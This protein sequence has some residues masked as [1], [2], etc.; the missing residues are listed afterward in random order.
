MYAAGAR[1]SLQRGAHR[2]RS[3]PNQIFCLQS[4]SLTSFV[5][6]ASPSVWKIPSQSRPV[7]PNRREPAYFARCFSALGGS[8]SAEKPGLFTIPGLLKPSDFLRLAHSAMEESDRLRASLSPEQEISTVD[9]ARYVL[10]RLDQISKTVCNVIDASEL[11]RNAHA[12]DEWRDEAQQ[13]FTLLQEYIGKLNGDESL[14]DSLTNVIKSPILSE[15]SEEE[16][17]FA[18]LLKS[19]FESEGIHLPAASKEQAQQLQAH[20]IKLETMFVTNITK[21]NKLFPIDREA[22]EQFIPRHVLKA[23]GAEY[24]HGDDGN[25]IHLTTTSPISNSI[26]SF[27]PSSSLRKEVYMETMTACP[28]NLNVLKNLQA[29]RHEMSNLLGFP[30]YADR[31]LV[32]K[33]ARSPK[34]VHQF[35]QQLQQHIRPSYQKDLQLMAYVKSQVE[36][37]AGATLDPWDLKYYMKL[38]KAQK[39]VD[40]AQLAPFLSLENCIDGMKILVHQLFDIQMKEEDIQETERWDGLSGQP[41]E[42]IRKF[43][44]RDADDEELG[45]MYLDLYP[46][47]GKYTHAAHFTVRCGC[48]V[49]GPGSEYQKPV[50]ALVCNM[51]TGQTSFSTHQEVETLYHEFG[52]ALHS[53]LSRTNFQHLSGTRVALDF[54]ETPSNWMECFV[55]DPTFLPFLAKTESGEPIPYELIQQMRQSKTLFQSLELQNQII[56]ATFDQ[57]LFGPEGK[58]DPQSTIDLWTSLHAEAGIPHLQGTHYHSTVGHLVSYGAGYYGYLYGQVFASDIWDQLFS[59]QP[60]DTAAGKAMWN[61][62]LRHGG[63]KDPNGI[64][65]DLLGRAPQ[66]D[67]YLNTL[68]V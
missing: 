47:Q 2:L 3:A 45:T 8:S 16:Q 1:A 58:G 35:L 67:R 68:I 66:V 27:A 36:G 41:E 60:L 56:L 17:R 57:H 50:V 18:S 43:I 54:V 34:H 14:Y 49:D 7:L 40:P 64:L 53:L 39:G 48:V 62:V 13:V 6:E 5:S 10:Y 52:H 46:R 32:D 31:F 38:L 65:R 19:E 28:E 24:P 26:T 25:E 11:C 63:A 12:S 23:H 55:W 51:N 4:L 30:S 37:D 42:R 20:V 59:K 15:L 61:K 33:M 9:Q 22:V 29:V 21:Y 44:F